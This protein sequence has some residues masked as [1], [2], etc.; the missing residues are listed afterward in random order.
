MCLFADTEAQPGPAPS[1][2]ARFHN[3]PSDAFLSSLEMEVKAEQQ[4]QKEAVFPCPDGPST[5]V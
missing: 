3:P 1:H 5:P 2:T 4:A